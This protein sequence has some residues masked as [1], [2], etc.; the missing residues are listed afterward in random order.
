MNHTRCETGKDKALI[1]EV[2]GN[3]LDDGPGIRTVVFFKGCPLSC[4]WCHNPESKKAQVEISFDKEKCIGCGSCLDACPEKALDR[5]NPSFVDRDRCT[6]CMTCAEECPSGALSQVGRY[7]DIDGLMR[8]IEKDIPFFEAS[9][10]GITLSGGEPTLFMDFVSKLLKRAKQ[11]GTHTLLET[12][13]FFDGPRFMKSLYPFLDTIYYDIKLFDP[14]EHRRLC[15]V[16]NDK[17]LHNFRMLRAECARHGKELLP[18]I[19]LIPGITATEKNLVSIARFLKESGV[20]RVE[21]LSYN[22]LW[23]SKLSLLGQPVLNGLISS[24]GEWMSG[25]QVEQCRAIFSDFR[26][27]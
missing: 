8:E 1:F 20:G 27:K 6:L 3:S 18:R 25:S 7:W 21:L 13:G 23:T 26:F 4:V 5:A 22:P 24:P 10:G 12:C 11:K 14:A 15:G 17:I 9:G 19:P 2:K 16:S